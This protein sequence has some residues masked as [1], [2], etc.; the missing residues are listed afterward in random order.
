LALGRGDALNDRA[1]FGASVTWGFQPMIE[2]VD[3]KRRVRFGKTKFR[4]LDNLLN[5]PQKMPN[6]GELVFPHLTRR[7]TRSAPDYGL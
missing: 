6:S 4:Q 5:L 1:R 3:H 2:G 7:Q